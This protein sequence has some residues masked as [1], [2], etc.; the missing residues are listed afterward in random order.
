[1]S[2][3]LA[4]LVAGQKNKNLTRTQIL[5]LAPLITFTDGKTKQA[6]KDETDINQIMKRAQVTGTISH[7]NKY[8]ARYGD[9]AGFDFLQNQIMTA[10]AQTIFDDLPPELRN[11]FHNSP[12]EFF[13]YVN[14]PKNKDD[15]PD[16]LPGLALP[17]RQ[18]F[19]TSPDN[20]DQDAARKLADTPPESAIA[21]DSTSGTTAPTSPSP[22]PAEPPAA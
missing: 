12:G 13:E 16:K 14:D 17:G 1:M 21:P 11:E 8:E 4:K 5:K 3:A 22:P 10:Q 9:F 7:I 15:L 20:A 18:N 2:H 6:F 19:A